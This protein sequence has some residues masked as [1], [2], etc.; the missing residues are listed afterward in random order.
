MPTLVV[1]AQDDM[2]TPRFYSDELARA[3]PGA[4][5]VVLEGGGH[6]APQILADPYNRAVGGFLRA[7]LA[8]HRASL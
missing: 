7:Q 3:I 4:R 8:P 6:F 2:V 5:H 1:V